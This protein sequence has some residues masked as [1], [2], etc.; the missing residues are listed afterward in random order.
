MKV[1]R[2]KEHTYREVLFTAEDLDLME[3]FQDTTYISEKLTD[4]EEICKAIVLHIMKHHPVASI[5]G[6]S[7]SVEEFEYTGQIIKKRIEHIEVS[8][9]LDSKIVCLKMNITRKTTC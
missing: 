4:N 5:T 1:L 7:Y 9:R 2:S 3:S 6:N 8:E